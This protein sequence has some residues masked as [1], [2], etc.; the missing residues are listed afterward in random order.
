MRVDVQAAL[1]PFMDFSSA[2]WEMLV[3]AQFL[4]R[5]RPRP[6]VGRD[7]RRTR[8]SIVGGLTLKFWSSLRCGSQPP[9]IQNLEVESVCLILH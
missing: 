8:R 4:P 3:G 7:T 1:S 9:S 5:R 2:K 6:I